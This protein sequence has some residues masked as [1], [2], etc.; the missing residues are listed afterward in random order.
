M[1]PS[2]ATPAPWRGLRATVRTLHPGS[3]ALVM[4]TGIVSLGL[5]DRGVPAL[6]AALLW[7]AAA[8][9]LTLVLLHLWRAAAFPGQ[10]RRDVADPARGFGFFTFVAG[11]DVLGARL[12]AADY[13]GTARVLLVIGLLGWLVLGYLVPG[14]M[15]VADAGRP[16]LAAANGRAKGSPFLAGGFFAVDSARKCSTVG[17]GRS[18][19][20]FYLSLCGPGF[21]VPGDSVRLRPLALRVMG[22]R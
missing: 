20:T 22:M 16:L 2:R 3:F 15:I 12:A 4:A 14:S 13:P 5:V 8:A 11:T 21:G 7:F 18:L 6:S 9:Y 1:E 17:T 19:W 10:L